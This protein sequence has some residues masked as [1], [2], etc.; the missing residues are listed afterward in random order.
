MN[1][2]RSKLNGYLASYSHVCKKAEEE[3]EA[4]E[5]AERRVKNTETAQKL[6]QEVAEY[7]Q[8]MAHKQIASVV[9]KSIEAV[10][11]D[12]GYEFKIRFSQKRGKTEAQLLFLKDGHEV[13]PTEGSGGGVVDVAALALRVAC[14]VLSRPKLRRLLIAD[15]PMKHVNGEEYQSRV[16]AMLETLAKEMNI[17]IIIATDDEWLHIGKVVAV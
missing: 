16:G 3:Q 8:E 6:V 17:Q 11:N 9:T 13:D 4:L 1:K 2:Y 12:L 5:K 15:E 7:T 10:F 14:I